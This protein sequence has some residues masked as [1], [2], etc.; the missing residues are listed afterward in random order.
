MDGLPPPNDDGISWFYLDSV[1]KEF[2]PFPND[3]MREWFMQGFFPLG[4][5]LLIRLPHWKQHVPLNAVWPE[6]RD[7]FIG[8]PSSL[9]GGSP[10][11]AQVDSY[12]PSFD[13]SLPPYAAADPGLMGRRQVEETLPL[14]PAPSAAQMGAGYWMMSPGGPGS[15]TAG[16]HASSVGGVMPPGGVPAHLGGLPSSMHGAL[17]G[18]VP[19]SP[20]LGGMPG[21]SLV[22]G[23]GLDLGLPPLGSMPMPGMPGMPGSIGS[24]PPPVA[25]PQ[26]GMPDSFHHCC[27]PA[28]GALGGI[29]HPGVL[30]QHRPLPMHQQPGACMHA[31]PLGLGTERFRGRIKSFNAKQGFGFIE[32]HDAYAIFGRDVFLHK[33]QIG[34]LKVGTEVTY[35]VEMNKQGMP[36]ARDLVTLD[37]Q[38]PGPAPPNVAKGGGKNKVARGRGRTAKDENPEAGDAGRREN[39]NRALAKGA[40]KGS[41]QATMPGLLPD[42]AVLGIHGGFP[43]VGAR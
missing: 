15:P 33:A 27:H 23:G 34:N 4:E 37:G 42:P 29:G 14:Y 9:Q 41:G 43:I 3:M 1:Q 19:G 7:A 24:M 12:A 5:E 28:L 35:G 6:V 8:L 38:A 2:G 25:M 32:N 17:A 16:A 10:P 21:S 36:Q 13:P 30:P 39:R 31:M 20:M 11:L 22:A 18:P 26:R 40:Q